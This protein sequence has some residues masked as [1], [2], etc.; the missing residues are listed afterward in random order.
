[1]NIIVH[2][3]LYLISLLPSILNPAVLFEEN[4]MSGAPLLVTGPLMVVLEEAEG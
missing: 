1:M 3:H 2:Y 4:L